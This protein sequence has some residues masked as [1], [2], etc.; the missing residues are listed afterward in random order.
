MTTWIQLLADG[1]SN[2]APADFTATI[3]ISPVQIKIVRGIRLQFFGL[4]LVVLS[5]FTCPLPMGESF[6]NPFRARFHVPFL[7]SSN[8]AWKYALETCRLVCRGAK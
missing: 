6:S 2:T 1:T 8:V 7:V 4:S 5:Y 3:R